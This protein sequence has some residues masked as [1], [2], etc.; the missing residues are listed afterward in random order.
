MTYLD[1]K[2]YLISQLIQYNY[3]IVNYLRI[4][5]YTCYSNILLDSYVLCKNLICLVKYNSSLKNWIMGVT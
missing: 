4:I 2:V 3:F 5:L 1:M